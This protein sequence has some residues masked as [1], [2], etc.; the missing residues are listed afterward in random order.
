[1]VA[2]YPPCA[3]LR[4]R[5][6]G[7]GMPVKKPPGKRPGETRPL[8]PGKVALAKNYARLQSARGDE[9]ENTTG[10]H[11]GN[12]NVGPGAPEECPEGPEPTDIDPDLV[13][14]RI[15]RSPAQPDP[16]DAGAGVE[17]IRHLCMQRRQRDGEALV[18]QSAT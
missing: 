15:Q 13:C 12:H 10:G 16:R 5:D 7:V 17:E 3:F 8:D 18:G 2:H 14:Y 4:L 9:S 6:M 11:H 1:S